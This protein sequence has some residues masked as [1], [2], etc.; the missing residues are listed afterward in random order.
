[1]CDNHVIVTSV[2]GCR[3][4]RGTATGKT[5]AQ[6]WCGKWASVG[7]WGTAGRGWGA[8]RGSTGYTLHSAARVPAAE[9]GSRSGAADRGSRCAG[10]PPVVGGSLP[11]NSK[12]VKRGQET[13]TCRICLGTSLRRVELATWSLRPPAEPE[14]TFSDTARVLI[15]R[16]VRPERLAE[17]A[18]EPP[19]HRRPHHGSQGAAASPC[20]VLT[21]PHPCAAHL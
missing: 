9:R 18:V 3:V 7:N 15:P 10:G 16:V 5:A 14:V 4:G 19:P 12:S 2:Y 21:Q 6:V 11:E 17:P 1:M 13:K 8:A 20:T